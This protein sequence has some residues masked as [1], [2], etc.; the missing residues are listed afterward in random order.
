MGINT[1]VYLN[2]ETMRK[3]EGNQKELK[4]ENFVKKNTQKL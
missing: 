1:S 4:E 3:D 2:S